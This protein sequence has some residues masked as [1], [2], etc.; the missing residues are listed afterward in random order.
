MS[1]T[2]TTNRAEE[3][4]ALTTTYRDAKEAF[5]RHRDRW[6]DAITDAVDEGMKPADVAGLVHV[7]PQRVQ[8]IVTRVYSRTE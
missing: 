1:R 5:E 8:A 3:L 4:T 2:I 7:S 6:H